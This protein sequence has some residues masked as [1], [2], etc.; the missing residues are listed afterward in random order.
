VTLIDLNIDL[1]RNAR[2]AWYDVIRAVSPR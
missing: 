2:Y 1:Q